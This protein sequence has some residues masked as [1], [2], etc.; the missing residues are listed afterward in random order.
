MALSE[1]FL[2]MIKLIPQPGTPIEGTPYKV[3]D[4][5]GEKY[6]VTGL[7]GK[8]GM[9]VV[10]LVYNK[11][12][13][14]PRALKSFREEF[15][16]DSRLRDKFRTE[17]EA[18]INLHRHMYVLEAHWV[19]EINGRLYVE[20]EC[21]PP[22][23][24]FKNSSLNDYIRMKPLDDK[25]MM[26]WAIQ[27]C[28]GMEHVNKN[29]IKCHLDIKPGNILI[30]ESDNVQ[31]SDFGL[32]RLFDEADSQLKGGI[33][34]TLPYMPPE[35]FGIGDFDVRNDIYS[36]G[37]VLYEM[38]TGRLPF[39]VRIPLDVHGDIQNV[40]QQ[41]WEKAHCNAPIPDAGGKI[42][43]IIKKCMAK[44][45]ADRYGSFGELRSDLS[46]YMLTKMGILDKT[47]SP[48][49]YNDN[50]WTEY[51]AKL[52]ALGRYEEALAC[53]EKALDIN[54][55]N[56]AAW[57]NKGYSL[58]KLGRYNEAIKCYN[59]SIK[60]GN[61]SVEPWMNLAACLNILGHDEEAVA[62]CERGLQIEA[63]NP[64]LWLNKG[65]SLRNLG[66]LSEAIKCFDKAI[67]YNPRYA[68]AWYNRGNTFFEAGDI[69][70]ALVSSE[71]A[72]SLDP[73][74]ADAWLCMGNCH[75]RLGK[76]DLAMRHFDKALSLNPRLIECWFNKG[77]LYGGQ[78]R[79]R[80]AVHCFEKFVEQAPPSMSNHVAEAR[81]H[82]MNLKKR[83]R[84]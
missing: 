75:T 52:A 65:N 17:V 72:A 59:Q 26:N 42:G 33:Q 5:I 57:N 41:E 58:T 12:Q 44:D 76:F 8:G 55:G 50:D 70:R 14:C 22:P 69:Q 48:E 37:V 79:Y 40:R 20:M 24:G 23:I 81:N 6:S 28:H 36:F 49:S 71:K 78:A 1:R 73:T 64:V 67:E 84:G 53:Y 45:R 83:M 2:H 21:I 82:I 29:G 60:S 25:Q 9:G 61:E 32:A 19:E 62:C 46:W 39:E 18:W 68:N 4:P 7:L 34:G 54:P 31:I 43:N 56:P 77:C 63:F 10:Y 66:Q 35:Q 16:L 11:K 15:L 80:E 3:F 47:P 51:G 30:N 27:F 38:V 74:L 13:D